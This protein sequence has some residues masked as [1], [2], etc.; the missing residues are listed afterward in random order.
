MLIIRDGFESGLFLNHFLYF[1]FLSELEV[2]CWRGPLS[3]CVS[4]CV[5][6]CVC[7]CV[8]LSR[9]TC[10]QRYLINHLTDFLETWHRGVGLLGLYFLQKLLM[11]TQGQGRYGL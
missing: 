11:F 2:P 7:L 1:Q 3:V 9:P 6:V 10:A 4:V 5:C 8:P